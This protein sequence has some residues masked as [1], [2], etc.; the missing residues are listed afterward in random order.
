MIK[1]ILNNKKAAASYA[2][3]SFYRI[4]MIIIVCLVFVAVLWMQYSKPYDIRKLENAQIAKK[5][6]LCMTNE[7]LVLTQENFNEKTLN[8]C[9]KTDNNVF[10]NFTFQGKSITS[11]KRELEVYCQVQTRVTGPYL[12]SC[13]NENYSVLNSSHQTDQLN[14]FIA[15]DK[16]S[17]NVQVIMNK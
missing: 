10:L 13:L 3:I 6:I 16:N 2:I 8:E 5:V 15:L 12:P 11:G 17:K 1:K 4:M 9:I 7:S 14:V